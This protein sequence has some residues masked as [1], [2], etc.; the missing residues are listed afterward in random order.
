MFV[1]QML[2]IT[3]NNSINGEKRSRLT[4]HLGVDNENE[5]SRAP[6]YHL[7][8]EG[9]VE[10]IY[11]TRKVPDLEADEGAVGHVLSA[12]LIG[13]L[14]EQGLVGGHLVEDHLLDG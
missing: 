8:V 9:G 12:D 3:L 11:L 6:E 10:E 2:L 4:I 13:A 5:R 7:V 1:P 14:Q